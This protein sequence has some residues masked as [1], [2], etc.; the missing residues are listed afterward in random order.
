MVKLIVKTLICTIVLIWILSVVSSLTVEELEN[1]Y[2]FYFNFGLVDVLNQTDYMVDLDT[3]GVNDTLTFNLTV[4][5]S[6]GFYDF[7]V[8]LIDEGFLASSKTNKTLTGGKDNVKV[9]F[10]SSLLSKNRYNYTIRVY[11][12]NR[13]LQYTKDKLVTS[14]YGSYETDVSLL[15]I[16]EY[17]DSLL[18][19]N[20]T[21]NSSLSNETKEVFLY[22]NYGNSTI[23]SAR[24]V[25]FTN[26]TFNATFDFGN[27]TIKRTHYIGAFTVNLVTYENKIFETNHNT[28]NYSYETFANT[29]YLQ[30][31]NI[32][33]TDNDNNSLYDFLEI[34]ASAV[35]FKFD[36]YTVDLIISSDLDTY[37]TNISMASELG[38]GT[39]TLNF[40]INGTDIYASKTNGPYIIKSAR[41]SDSVGVIDFVQAPNLSTTYAYTDFEK[42]ALP[43]LIVS[44]TKINSSNLTDNVNLTINVTNIGNAPAFNMV[45]FIFDNRTYIE[46]ATIGFLEINNSEIVNFSVGGVMNDPLYFAVIDMENIVDEL[47]DS[48]NAANNTIA[49]KYT[50]NVTSLR[51]IYSNGTLRIFEFVVS[52]NGTGQVNGISWQLYMGDGTVINST[53]NSTLDP[54]QNLSVY[55]EYDYARN[56]NYTVIAVVNDTIESI[57]LSVSTIDIIVQNLSVLNTT[58]TKS[59]IGFD[60]NNSLSTNLTNVFWTFD[61]NYARIVNATSN[62]TLK[63][64][65]RIFIYVE[66]NFTNSGAYNLNATARNGSLI[67]WKNIS[68]V[69]S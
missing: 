46:N 18:H 24:N 53:I 60:I 67:D 13:R 31:F 19:I 33:A 54:R 25:T 41:L 48:N 63:P 23:Y 11:D 4:N 26:S 3:D 16:K 55:V 59:I 56:D 7:I 14:N 61:V 30:K 32:T 45:L 12:A 8:D 2:D 51:E 58:G 37:V 42:P 17:T 57:S 27:E 29:S 36:N 6:E 9:N 52:N 10:S 47:N 43:D 35:V 62:V 40:K 22:L 44:I 64:N 15:S 34:N 49:L 1:S 39:K 50:F 28:S 66:H 38:A 21:F 69:I 68:L 20:L 5:G 65:E